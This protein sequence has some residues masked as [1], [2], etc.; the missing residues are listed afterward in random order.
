[1]KQN[2][3]TILVPVIPDKVHDLLSQLKEVKLKSQEGISKDLDGLGIIHYARWVVIDHGKSWI[4]DEQKRAPKLLFVVDYDGNEAD[5]LHKVCESTSTILDLIYVFCND[6]P[7][8]NSINEKSRIDYLRYHIIKDTAVYIG[9]PG[10]SVLQIQNERKLRNYIRNFLDSKSWIGIPAQEVL[11]EIQS[12]VMDSGDFGFL[13][14]KNVSFPRINYPVLILVGLLVLILLPIWLPIVLIWMF[15]LHFFYERKDEN[16]TQKRSQLDDGYLTDLEK[17]EDWKNQNQFTQLVDMKEGSLRLLSIKFMFMLTNFLIK[18]VFNQGKL[19]GI[20]TIH[21]AKWVMFEKN[22]RVL[23][24]SNFDGSWQQYL[25]DF[26]DNSG[27]GLTGIFSN[28]KAFPKTNFLITGGAYREEYFLAWS[29]NSELITN[30]WYSAYPDLS[31]KN[32]NNN[33]KIRVQLMQALSDRQ[34]TKFL[35]LL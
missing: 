35:K 20:P 23:F 13:E 10:R 6:Y 28:T 5:M 2:S 21:F 22:S 15:I 25:G 11:Q 4:N 3:I 7:P 30:F 31:I 27:W 9:A 12:K 14:T 18:M 33:T 8:L 32:V 34:A 16:F 1:M 19:M 26:I 29:R 17:Y 24:S